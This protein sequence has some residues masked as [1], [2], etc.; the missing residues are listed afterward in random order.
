L[1]LI[2]AEAQAQ[3][4]NF[5]EAV[6]AINIVRNSWNLPDFNSSDKDEMTRC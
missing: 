2:Y 1:I 5:P 6:V 3:L 4:D